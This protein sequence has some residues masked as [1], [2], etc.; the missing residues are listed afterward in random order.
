MNLKKLG[1]FT[2]IEIFFVLA[3]VSVL[4]GFGISAIS[5]I[6]TLSKES[7]TRANLSMMRSALL[8]Y[9]QD[10]NG[11]Y[12]VDDL[13]CLFENEKYIEKIPQAKLAAHGVSNKVYTGNSED[14]INDEGGWAYVNVVGDDNWGKLVVNCTHPDSKGRI[15][16]QIG[17]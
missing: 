7:D 9:Y 3:V 15:W 12:P 6:L 17:D 10:N 8:I 5:K 2:L 14:Y 16:S 11:M 4:F 13:S 1:G